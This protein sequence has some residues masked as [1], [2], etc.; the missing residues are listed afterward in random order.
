MFIT[1]ETADETLD[2]T[3]LPAPR[4]LEEAGLRL[5]LII[6]LVIKALHFAG[7]LAG[8]HIAERL[9]LP[10]SVIE[11]AIDSSGSNRKDAR[12]LRVFGR[13]AVE[14]ATMGPVVSTRKNHPAAGWL[15]SSDVSR[16]RTSKR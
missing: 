10:F 15:T 2:I 1:D 8:V 5:D 4:T 6:Q 3:S 12:S 16:A 11:P 14:N 13:G 9:G 7:E